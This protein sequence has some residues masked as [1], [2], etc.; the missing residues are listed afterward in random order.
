MKHI[1]ILMIFVF[2]L[3]LIQWPVFAKTY[4]VALNGKDTNSG[5]I[6]SP[7]RTIKK[8]ITLLKAGDTLFVHPGNYGYEYNIRFNISG[9][10]G[11]PIVVMAE[12][13]G[14]VILNGPRKPNEVECPQYDE[15]NEGSCFINA[16]ASNIVLDGFNISNYQVGIEDGIW[17]D[18]SNTNAHN[19]TIKNCV[20]HNNASVAIQ[21]YRVKDVHILNC[22]FMS[23]EM[24]ERRGWNA[25]QDYGVNF[26]I[27]SDCV[28]ENCYFY[29][30]HN[31]SLAFKEG[32]TNCVARKNIFEGVGHFG[33]FLGQNRISNET[34]D[35]DNPTCKNLTAE[36]N[37][38]RPTN[39]MNQV[40]PK[41]KYRMKTP[42]VIDNVDGAIV[43]N[44]YIEGFD[45]GNKTCGINLFNEAQGEI[46]IYNNIIAFGV[47][48]LMSGG[49]FQDWGFEN[50]NDVEIHHNTFYKVSTDFINLRHEADIIWHFTK[51]LAYKTPFYESNTDKEYNTENFRG[52]P[53]FINGDPVQQAITTKADKKDFDLYYKNLTEPFRLKKN[54]KAKGFGAMP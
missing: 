2:L 37:I 28:V 53:Q 31:Q 16:N 35:N 6:K 36:Y 43:R 12:K 17:G 50:K 42:I 8:G 5:T 51:N 34:E 38:F 39:G 30:E 11:K 29:G 45:D 44:N 18:Q 22:T 20:L 26:Y 24:P 25:I 1:K 33:I 52:N 15:L 9:T 13:A 23:D 19:I 54:S 41:R 10:K 27:C 40:E 21:N 3:T 4:H 47:P 48:N 7:L 49:I 46:E 14:T 32:D